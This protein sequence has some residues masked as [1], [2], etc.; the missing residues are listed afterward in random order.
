MAN[1][2]RILDSSM[3]DIACAIKRLEYWTEY[4]TRLE[5]NFT[6]YLIPTEFP[7]LVPFYDEWDFGT[8]SWNY[9]LLPYY[10]ERDLNQ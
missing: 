1:K 8:Y 2:I 9:F 7:Y 3:W 5:E 10:D 4:W 6:R